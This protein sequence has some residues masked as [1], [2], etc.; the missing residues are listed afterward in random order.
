MAKSVDFLLCIASHWWRYE[1][2]VASHRV[3]NASQIAMRYRLSETL[4]C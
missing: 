1:N 4:G 3:E 2:H